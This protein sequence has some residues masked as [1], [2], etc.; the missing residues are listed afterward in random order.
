MI[1]DT[2]NFVEI[3]VNDNG[4]GIEPRDLPHMFERFY[5][6]AKAKAEHVIGTGLGLAIAKL[7]VEMHGGKIWVESPVIDQ[8][9]FSWD[10]RNGQGTK[11]VFSLPKE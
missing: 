11:F 3:E 7:L 2:G 6:S 5:R 9:V 1:K 10:K 8:E 4:A